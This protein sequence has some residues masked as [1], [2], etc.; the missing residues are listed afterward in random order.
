MG[1]RIRNLRRWITDFYL[2]LCS[3]N[4]YIQHNGTD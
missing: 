4:N 2:Y 1:I 3:R